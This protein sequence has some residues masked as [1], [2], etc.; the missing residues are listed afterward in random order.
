MRRT[1]IAITGAGPGEYVAA[2]RATQLGAK[3][4]LIEKQ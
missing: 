2:L 1:E 3:I 4:F